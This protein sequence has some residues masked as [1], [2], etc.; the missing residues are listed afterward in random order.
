MFKITYGKG[1]EEKFNRIYRNCIE[2]NCDCVISVLGELPMSEFLDIFVE[3]IDGIDTE[4]TSNSVTIEYGFGDSIT[5]N[6]LYLD[7]NGAVIE[8]KF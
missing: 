3:V 2:D 5:I 6:V 1:T 4:I 8:L 7:I